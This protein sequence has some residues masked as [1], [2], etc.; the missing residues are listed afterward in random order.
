MNKLIRGLAVATTFAVSFATHASD[1]K[2]GKIG[3]WKATVLE[4][5]SVFLGNAESA[6]TLSNSDEEVTSTVLVEKLPLVAVPETK[7]EWRHLIF[8]KAPKGKYV[9]MNERAFKMGPIERYVVEFRTDI[10]ADAML[11]TILMAL[12]VNGEIY[13]FHY[14]SFPKTFADNV[15]SVRELFRTMEVTQQVQSLAKSTRLAI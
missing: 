5:T 7:E 3:L 2:V 12:S 4:K 10:G 1:I 13:A 6:L 15:R 14:Q 8:L 11:H 9:V